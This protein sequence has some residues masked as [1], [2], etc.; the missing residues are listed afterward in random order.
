MPKT[1]L[2]HLELAISSDSHSTSKCQYFAQGKQPIAVDSK[3]RR[4]EKL[5]FNIDM[6]NI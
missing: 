2:N 4:G 3:G 1:D 5:I 6:R